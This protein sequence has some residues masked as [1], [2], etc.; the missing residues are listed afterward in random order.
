M[1]DLASRNSATLADQAEAR[2]T[3]QQRLTMPHTRMVATIIITIT[4]TIMMTGTTTSIRSSGRKP[5]GLVLSRL[6]QRLSGSA[7]GSR[8]PASARS[9]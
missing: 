7:S 5:F 9:G 2:T 1:A 8:L 6:L 4:T 3:A